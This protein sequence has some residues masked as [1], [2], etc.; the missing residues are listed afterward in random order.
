MKIRQSETLS[1]NLAFKDSNNNDTVIQNSN[2]DTVIYV[3]GTFTDG[4]PENTHILDLR[5]SPQETKIIGSGINTTKLTGVFEIQAY[6][7]AEITKD[8]PVGD[9]SLVVRTSPTA[10]PRDK[11][12]VEVVYEDT[13]TIEPMID[14]TNGQPFIYTT[15]RNINDE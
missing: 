2:Y 9:Y 12:I 15:P 7:P 6:I 8:I 1:F 13:V 4:T 10:E 14:A 5:Y 11:D 3:H